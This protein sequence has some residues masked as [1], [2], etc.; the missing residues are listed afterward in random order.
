MEAATYKKKQA[1][2]WAFPFHDVTNY[3]DLAVY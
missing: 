1:N 2:Y 3:S